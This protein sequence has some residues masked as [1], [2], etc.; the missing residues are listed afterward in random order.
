MAP[1][2]Q[3]KELEDILNS[4]QERLSAL[5][6]QMDEQQ[7]RHATMEARNDS[8]QS[9]LTLLL[10]HTIPPH[11]HQSSSS[12]ETPFVPAATTPIPTNP[13]IPAPQTMPNPN[14]HPQYHP[15]NPSNIRPPKLL[16]A[17]FEGSD[18]LDWLFQ[19]EQYFSFY[20]IL[21][22][23]RLSMV[24]F[25]MKGEA[26][27][28]FKLL[29]QNNLVTDW[30]SFTRALELRF[31][32]STYTNHQALLF[33]LQ[34]V[35]TV[36]E[37]QTR[38]EKLCNCTV[39]LTPDIILN[40]FISSLHPDIRRELSILNPYSISQAIGLAKLIEDKYCDSKPR[41]SRPFQVQNY[42]TIHTSS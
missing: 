21:L 30:V 7:T 31:G 16:L 37:Y 38:F 4:T 20:Q 19:A 9:T 34:Q 26:L 25:H 42:N 22:A 15:P 14:P 2:L 36:T 3:A 8:T 40:C 5:Q 23:Q 13:Q 39:G 27:S 11:H 18:P 6:F 24:A 10:D 41:I 12:A 28:W 17:F 32:P 35:T 33:K 1:K 29:H